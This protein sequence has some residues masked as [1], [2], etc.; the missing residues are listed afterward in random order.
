MLKLA[1]GTHILGLTKTGSHR[2]ISQYFFV[3]IFGSYPER[4][5]TND[6]P[7]RNGKEKSK[8]LSEQIHMGS[9]LHRYLSILLD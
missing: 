1:K 7:I 4:G 3:V 6:P 5:V 9:Y 2:T 8:E